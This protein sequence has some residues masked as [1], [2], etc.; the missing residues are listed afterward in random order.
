[1]AAHRPDRDRTNKQENTH[2]LSTEI[3]VR[4]EKKQTV[5]FAVLIWSEEV[6]GVRS[7][8]LGQVNCCISL[9]LSVAWV[10]VLG[11]LDYNNI[12]PY[13]AARINLTRTTANSSPV[14]YVGSLHAFQK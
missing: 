7:G 1:M 2:G 9:S 4:I 10:V 12:L 14:S 5:W 13:Y 11:V 3:C 8:G 6:W